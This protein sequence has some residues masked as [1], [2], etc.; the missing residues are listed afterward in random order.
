MEGVQWCVG[1]LTRQRGQRTSSEPCLVLCDCLMHLLIYSARRGRGVV[2]RRGWSSDE[3]AEGKGDGRSQRVLAL[4]PVQAVSEQPCKP[5]KTRTPRKQAVRARG[6]S[7]QQLA[8]L[9]DGRLGSE[10]AAASSLRCQYNRERHL[11]D[12]K[13]VETMN[14]GCTALQ[15]RRI[16]NQARRFASGRQVYGRGGSDND[17]VAVCKGGL[18]PRCPPPWPSTR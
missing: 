14:G 15:E 16:R 13:R 6:C 8:K 5:S 17:D 9:D 10:F 4:E 2:A 1:D 12:R 3:G 7:G 11:M 18:M